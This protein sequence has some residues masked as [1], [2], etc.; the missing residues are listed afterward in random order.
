M[1]ARHLRNVSSQKAPVQA[2]PSRCE[3]TTGKQSTSLTKTRSGRVFSVSLARPGS[4]S[5]R[6]PP[7]SWLSGDANFKE[8]S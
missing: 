7:P 4:H 6:Q 3:N 8:T 1:F 2:F 5:I